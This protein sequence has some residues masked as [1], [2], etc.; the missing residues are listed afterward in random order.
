MEWKKKKIEDANLKKLSISSPSPSC[1]QN[2]DPM[3]ED[4]EKGEEGKEL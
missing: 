1:D 4:D 2:E 3:K